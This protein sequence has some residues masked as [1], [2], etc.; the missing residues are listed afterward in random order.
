MLARRFDS[1]PLISAADHP[2][3]GG[4]VNGPS[5]IRVPSWLPNPLG[6]YYMYFA[7]HQGTSIRLAYADNIEGPW[8]LYE[9][10]TL[11]L[12]ETPCHGHIASP[13]VHVLDKERLIK[14]YYHGPALSPSLYE[15]DSLFQQFPYLGGQRSFTALSS[16]GLSFISETGILGSSY[17]RFFEWQGEGFA[18]G[19]PGL[20]Y[21]QTRVK[22]DVFEQGPQLFEMDCRHFAVRVTESGTLDCFF[23]RAG[24]KPERI[25][26]ATIDLN[27]PNCNWAPASIVEVLRPEVDYEGATQPLEKSERGAVHVPVRQLRDPCILQD[28][29]KDFLFYSLAGE[30]G[31]GGATLRKSP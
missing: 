14:M 25:L 1:N 16:D 18:L 27:E 28:E 11:H 15:S 19:M 8:I 20:L 22:P 23:T 26:M 17:F 4:N 10:G 3:L 9:P 29:E 6:K 21:R 2:I 31:I 12:S 24:D 7:H 30:Q 5:V 13:D